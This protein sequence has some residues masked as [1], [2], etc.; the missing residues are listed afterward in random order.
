VDSSGS[1]IRFR[2]RDLFEYGPR[3]DAILCAG[4]GER[5]APRRA[6]EQS[7]SDMCFECADLACDGGI[8]QAQAFGRSRETAGVDDLEQDL[9]AVRDIQDALQYCGKRNK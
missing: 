3:S 8:G 6:V 9:H 4:F 7:R 5:K 2:F 1:R